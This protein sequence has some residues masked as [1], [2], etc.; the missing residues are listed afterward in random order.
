MNVRNITLF[1]FGWILVISSPVQAQL[2]LPASQPDFTKM[3][4]ASPIASKPAEKKYKKILHSTFFT[5]N[6]QSLPLTKETRFFDY[7][8]FSYGFKAGTMRNSGWFLSFM[9]NFRLPGTFISGSAEQIQNPLDM[10]TS[11]YEGMFGLTGRYWKPMSF[12]F[13][14]GMNYQTTNYLCADQIWRHRKEE[15]RY[16][17]VVATGFMF[18]IVGFAISGEAVFHY[19]LQEGNWKDNIYIGA[20]VGIGF[21]LVDKKG[22]KQAQIAKEQK[23][24][25]KRS[26]V[27]ITATPDRISQTPKGSATPNLLIADMPTEIFHTD[28]APTAK[29]QPKT[30]PTPVPEVT[31]PVVPVVKQM[32]DTTT[33][34]TRPNDPIAEEDAEASETQKTVQPRDRITIAALIADA[35]SNHN[36]TLYLE[37]DDE[38]YANGQ[39]SDQKP[40]GEMTITDADHNVYRTV[41]IGNQCWMA[42]N[43]RTKTDPYGHTILQGRHADTNI[44]YRYCPGDDTANVRTYGYLYNWRAATGQTW[45][46][47]QADTLGRGICPK[48]WHLPTQAEWDLMALYLGSY[49]DFLCNGR[50]RQIGKALAATQG[51]ILSDSTCTV[52]NNPA[53]NNASGF[54][55]LPAGSYN[56]SYSGF[57]LE[58]G[59]WCQAPDGGIGQSRYLRAD[60]TTLRREASAN[61]F[62]AYS[63]RC[64]MD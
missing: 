35:K 61:P 31:T 13:G 34:L 3:E 15:S 24:S 49:D 30:V 57:G 1:L 26:L 22:K 59:F 11:Y 48:G 25:L 53:T 10:R 12:H 52:G 27:P 2:S 9:T 28:T 55:A 4:T 38:S 43:L 23:G 33:T 21:C 42:E 45:F 64:V 62:A 46:L 19:A 58:A 44:A 39:S 5:F 17:P 47:P 54:S 7:N 37:T 51:W 16:G 50:E 40:C 32:Q 18:H 8:N 14:V 56:G 20:K 29:A 60:D 41:S 6:M 36:D 63:I